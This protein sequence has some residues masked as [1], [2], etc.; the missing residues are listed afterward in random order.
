MTQKTY[1]CLFLLN[2]KDYY[3]PKH[4]FDKCDRFEQQLSLEDI[5]CLN[6]VLIMSE[7]DNEDSGLYYHRQDEDYYLDNPDERKLI[8][9]RRFECEEMHCLVERVNKH[10]IQN[11]QPNDENTGKIEIRILLKNINVCERKVLVEKSPT[12]DYIRF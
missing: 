1:N 2:P 3:K 7:Y 6:Q 9:T 12:E 4:K 8:G 5:P 10:Y 11:W